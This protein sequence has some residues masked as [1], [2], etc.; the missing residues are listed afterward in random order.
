MVRSLTKDKGRWNPLTQ[1][2]DP[3]QKKNKVQALNGAKRRKNIS[4]CH[5]RTCLQNQG[6]V[7]KHKCTW[8]PTKIVQE[9]KAK[10]GGNSPAD[11]GY[12]LK[13]SNLLFKPAGW[14]VPSLKISLCSAII[15]SLL[16]P[17][18]WMT[19]MTRMSLIVHDEGGLKWRAT[20][21]PSKLHLMERRCSVNLSA[22]LLMVS[23]TYRILQRVQ[24]MA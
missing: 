15:R 16:L 21:K 2:N 5:I 17:L 11:N 6:N 14:T 1:V 20:G 19:P 13:Q 12:I 3:I 10:V 7:R 24:M 8:K 4:L 18:A 23:P 22:S 9:P